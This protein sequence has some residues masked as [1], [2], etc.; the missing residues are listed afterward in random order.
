MVFGF[1]AKK[2]PECDTLILLIGK[3]P[4]YYQILFPILYK[5]GTV[6]VWTLAVSVCITVGV[7]SFL[8]EQINPDLILKLYRETGKEYPETGTQM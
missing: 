5:R 7:L 6:V 8:T 3:C 1:I 4:K 2:G